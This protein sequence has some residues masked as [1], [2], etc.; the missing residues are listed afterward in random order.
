MAV[1]VVVELVAMLEWVARRG[2]AVGVRVHAAVVVVVYSF[3]Y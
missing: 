3:G 2:R 1:R